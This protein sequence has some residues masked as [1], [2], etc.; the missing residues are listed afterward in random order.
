MKHALYIAALAFGLTALNG[1]TPAAAANRTYDCSK[2]GNATKAV[3][4][5]TARAAAPAAKAQVKVAS[6]SGATKAKPIVVATKTERNYDC[7]KAGNKNKAQCKTSAARSIVASAMPAKR[8]AVRTA[9]P[10]HRP[11]AA[12]PSSEN[13]VAAGA[14]ARCK[15]GLYSHAARRDGACSRHGGVGAWLKG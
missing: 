11:A 13:Q 8:P 10:M 2:P 15:D 5:S 14:I 12:A 7:G 9:A 6:K 1:A 4:K 3:C